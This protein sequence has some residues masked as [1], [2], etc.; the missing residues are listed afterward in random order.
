[1]LFFRFHGAKLRIYSNNQEDFNANQ[2]EIN[3]NQREFNA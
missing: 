2:V 1:M 3:A